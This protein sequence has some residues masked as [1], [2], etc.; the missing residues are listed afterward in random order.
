ML[1]SRYDVTTQRVLILNKILTNKIFCYVKK[2]ILILC[3]LRLLLNVYMAL[4]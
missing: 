1:T 4:L 2:E 3:Y